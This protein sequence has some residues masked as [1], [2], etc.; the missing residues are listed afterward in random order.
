MISHGKLT[1]LSVFDGE[2]DIGERAVFLSRL[3]DRCV[4]TNSLRISDL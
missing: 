1:H 3:Q 4:Y 2:G